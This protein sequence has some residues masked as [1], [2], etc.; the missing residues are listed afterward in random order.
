LT[1]YSDDKFYEAKN[2]AQNIIKVDGYDFEKTLS[3]AKELSKKIEIPDDD[4]KIGK[5]DFYRLEQKIA[6]AL[7][8]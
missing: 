3:R 8:L 1:N 4:F 7:F 5:N 6:F 2:V